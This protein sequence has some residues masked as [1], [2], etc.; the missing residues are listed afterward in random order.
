MKKRTGMINDKRKKYCMH[1]N[2]LS[3]RALW[4]GF[5]IKCALKGAKCSSGSRSC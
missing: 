3:E 2:H 5:P 1:G 4:E